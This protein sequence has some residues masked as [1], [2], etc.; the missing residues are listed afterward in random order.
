MHQKLFA[1]RKLL[2][3]SADTCRPFAFSHERKFDIMSESE[4]TRTYQLTYFNGDTITAYHVDKPTEYRYDDRPHVMKFYL[5]IKDAA[6]N[7]IEGV[8]KHDANPLE[9]AARLGHNDLK[10]I[11]VREHNQ[12]INTYTCPMYYYPNT[13]DVRVGTI[14]DDGTIML[15]FKLL[16]S[17]TEHPTTMKKMIKLVYPDAIV[18]IIDPKEPFFPNIGAYQT[19]QFKLDIEDLYRTYLTYNDHPEHQLINTFEL[20]DY[21]HNHQLE[22]VQAWKIEDNTKTLITEWIPYLNDQ[23]QLGFND[24]DFIIIS[25]KLNLLVLPDDTDDYSY[26]IN[27]PKTVIDKIGK[28]FSK[29]TVTYITIPSAK[30]TYVVK[31]ALIKA[32]YDNPLEYRLQSMTFKY[33]QIEID[34]SK[35]ATTDY[36]I[37]DESKMILNLVQNAI[38]SIK[39]KPSDTDDDQLIEYSLPFE[40]LNHSVD[41]VNKYQHVQFN[42]DSIVISFDDKIHHVALTTEQWILQIHETFMKVNQDFTSTNELHNAYQSGDYLGIANNVIDQMIKSRFLESFIVKNLES[43][44]NLAFYFNHI[45]I[46]LPTIIKKLLANNQINAT[47]NNDDNIQYIITELSNYIDH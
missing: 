8:H 33:D 3:R 16:E 11:Q 15:S 20:D 9:I 28:S 21:I 6:L 24:H 26:V 44:K 19:F 4:N 23:V 34:H 5:N 46:D 40:K 29:E 41:F 38:K 31:N 18:T 36:K 1:A 2:K 12:I 37:P 30:A 42:A 13:T 32:V 27:D 43:T 7:T 10:S 45:R 25:F 14:H 22:K 17:K 35:S 47:E 39:T